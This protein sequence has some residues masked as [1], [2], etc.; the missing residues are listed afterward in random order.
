MDEKKIKWKNSLDGMTT[1]TM[2]SAKIEALREIA[3][4][5]ALLNEKLEEIN[6]TN[7]YKK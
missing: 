5:L 3:E 6:T 4:Q 1:Q 2:E 7:R